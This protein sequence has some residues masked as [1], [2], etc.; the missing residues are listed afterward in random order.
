MSEPANTTSSNASRTLPEPSVVE[1][2]D[3][4]PGGQLNLLP[5][6]ATHDDLKVWFELWEY[7]DPEKGEESVELFL[8]DISIDCRTWNAPIE[9]SDRYV[10]VPARL[11]RNND[12][13]RRLRYTAKAYN[14]EPDNSLELVITLDTQAPVLAFNDSLL[15][16]PDLIQNGLSEQYL[17]EHN[18]VVTVT[19]PSYLD[20]PAPGDRITAKWLNE[21]NGHYQ[22]VTKDLDRDNYEDPI[23]L[24]FPE[25]LIRAMGDGMRSISYHVTDRAGN[26][27]VES[28]AVSI[29]VSVVR[30]P[31][32]VPRPWITQA[33]G[34][35]AEYADLDPQKAVA[36]ATAQI[37]DDA[38]YYDD[39]VVHMQFGE[40]G[41]VGAIAIP[42]PWGT[43]QVRVPAA[44]IAAAF[45][46]QLPVYYDVVLADTSKKKSG[47]LTLQVLS[48]PTHRFHVP[49]LESPFTDPVSKTSIPA[50]GLP[51]HQ[52]AWAFISEA[53]LV[54]VTVTGRNANAQTVSEV[55]L[56]AHQVLPAQVSAGIHVKVS[57]RFMSSLVANQKFTVETKVSFDQGANWIRFD[58][59]TPTLLE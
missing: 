36:G 43:K 58:T 54:T 12:G 45:N 25:A 33:E 32:F 5:E 50:A 16:D 11:L 37:P 55:V 47:T 9:A 42:V 53:S 31:H 20:E 2:L 35:P 52:R 22:E 41:T 24:E 51:V 7:S 44:N 59:L 38:V 57:Q 34:S 13:R 10:T 23:H 48:Y 1:L 49:Q 39:D 3:N 30:A 8:D 6:A 15:I 26:R 14:G 46:K 27:S 21:N 17:D 29:L 40:P 18:G 4:I 28:T 19:V 56:N